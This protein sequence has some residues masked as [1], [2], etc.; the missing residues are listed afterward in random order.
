MH[1]LYKKKRN[2]K[3]SELTKGK[4]RNLKLTLMYDGGNYQGWQRLNMNSNTIQGVLETIVSK[5]FGESIKII[6]SGRTDVGVHALGQVANFQITDKALENLSC[7]Q[8][9]QKLNQILPEDIK[10]IMLENVSN[11]F[12]SR[13]DAISKTYEYHIE[14]GERTSVFQRKYVA[15]IGKHLDLERMRQ[16]CQLLKGTHDFKGFSSPMLDGRNTIKTIQEVTIEARNNHI[17]ISINADGFLYH[18]VRIIVGTLVEIGKNER[19]CKTI[20]EIFETKDRQL[21]GYTIESQGLFL[22]NVS[23]I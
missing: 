20:R 7:E 19:E 11:E 8:I 3:E 10:I 5:E 4:L 1:K 13:Y 15:H 17:V 6:G 23:Y 18:M 22:K 14:M 12:H 16:A 2:K 9:K 21:A